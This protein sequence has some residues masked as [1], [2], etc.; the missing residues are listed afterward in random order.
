MALVSQQLLNGLSFGGIL[1]L[2][3]AGFSLSFGVL[4]VL[5]LAHG[6]LYAV[7]AF[8]GWTIFV[9]NLLS[10]VVMLA[11]FFKGH[12]GLARRLTA[13]WAEED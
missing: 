10:T 1:F 6:A 12:R 9:G 3:A 11:Y 2:V 4:R 7:G 13:A 5:N 8:L